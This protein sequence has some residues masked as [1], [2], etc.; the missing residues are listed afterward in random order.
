MKKQFIEAKL[1]RK[2][3][4]LSFVA[5]DETLDRAGEV[6]PIETWDLT[7]FM[8]NPVLL[9][10]H[11][12]RVE[13]IV[14]LAKNL[15]IQGK[16]L[17]FDVFFHGLTELAKSVAEMVKEEVLNTVSVGF[18]PHGPEKDGDLGR[19]ELLEI[20]FVAVPAN[21]NA[22][23]LKSL[24]DQV[25]DEKKVEIKSWLEKQN[26][27]LE[28]IRIEILKSKFDSESAEKWIV[29]HN[30]KFVSKDETEKSFVF[31]LV[32]KDVECE[33]EIKTIEFEDGVKLF[34]CRIT[35]RPGK[36]D[37]KNMT[38]IE[39][40]IEQLANTRSVI[41]DKDFVIAQL[42]EGRVLSGRNRKRIEDAVSILKQASEALVE[43]LD[44]TES[45]KDAGQSREPKVGHDVKAPVKA[46]S[47][48]VRALQRINSE[49]NRILS[50]IKD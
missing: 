39:E 27:I 26:E 16:K 8:R 31:H 11:D 6:I 34:A 24:A 47:R 23:R 50:E 22:E 9:V 32:N 4:H 44:A 29:D 28:A 40:L 37:E 33:G 12:Y 41:A 42:K 21:P 19:N 45:G 1:E 3:D 17:L 7:N 48:V 14:G 35:E 30:Y 2:G 13:N 20:S 5:S 18:I 49:S 36:E 15:R 10:N 25:T 46:Q 43:L 38:E